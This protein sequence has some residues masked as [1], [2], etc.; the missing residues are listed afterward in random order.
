MFATGKAGRRFKAPHTFVI[1]FSLIVFAVFL[2]Y[3]VPAGKFDRVHDDRTGRTL[4]VADSYHEIDNTPVSLLKIPGIL[5][6][7]TVDAAGIVVFILM[8]GGSFEIV[9]STGSLGAICR[10]V[11]LKFKGRE[12]L[13]IVLFLVI[14]SIFGTTM[15]MSAEVMI[16]VPLGITLAGS[17]G[18]DRVTG[19]A[20]I[21]MGAACGF[22]AGVMN[23]FNVGIAQSVAELPLFSGWEYRLFIL[24]VL[25]AISAAYIIRYSNK[26][27]ADP[28]LS[29]VFDCEEEYE[30]DSPDLEELTGRH[31]MV[32]LTV[33][34]SLAVLIWG[35]GSQ[36]WWFEEMTAIFLV[37]GVVSGLVIGYSPSRIASI[38][39]VGAKN[40]AVG[41]LIVGFARG[42][43]VAM[44]EGNIIDSIV[45]YISGCIRELPGSVQ[46]VGVFGAQNVINAIITSGSG[47]AVVTMPVMTPLADLIGMSRQTAVLAFQLGDGFTNSILPTSASLMGFLSVARIPYERWLRFML[48]LLGLWLVAGA[49]FMLGAVYIGY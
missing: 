8:I 14:F 30:D 45:Y 49:L 16:F 12:K 18:F 28:S 4:V 36:G 44:N 32:L 2:T 1:L 41:A 35:V 48:P 9:N 47:Q 25:L 27:K 13:L 46:T 24:I 10:M 11:A 6:A 33:G 34:I 37:M 7:G 39:G 26:V 15:G 5:Y 43:Q 29:V 20:M 38:F 22:T 21:A 3:V 31:V 17:M 42:I 23:P 40:I 19:T